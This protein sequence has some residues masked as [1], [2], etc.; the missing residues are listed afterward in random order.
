MSQQLPIVDEIVRDVLLRL[1]SVGQGDQ[2]AQREQHDPNGVNPTAN[3]RPRIHWLRNNRS[4]N[5]GAAYD[6]SRTSPQQTGPQPS[7][8]Q[9]SRPQSNGF[10]QRV[11]SDAGGTLR[12]TQG[13]V[14]LADVELRLRGIDR[15]E[16]SDQTIVTPAARDYL[17]QYKVPLC[18]ETAHPAG[19]QTFGQQPFGQKNS[20]VPQAA[21]VLVATTETT[22]RS[23]ALES[24]LAREGYQAADFA[25]GLPER[26]IEQLVQRLHSERLLGVLI[27]EH[28][29]RALALANRDP[30]VFAALGISPDYL[31]EC[32]AA[33]AV[34][35]LVVDPR[36]CSPWQLRHMARRL[37]AVG[38]A[39]LS[40]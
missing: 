3:N 11:V 33:M 19:L 39:H 17:N 30:R 32:L 18:R 15:V 1:R 9:P 7:R 29:G 28:T 31:E 20:D 8:P 23:A 34:N 25:G 27:T 40:D 16:V 22:Q 4:R 24:I 12:F 13:V 37:A 38:Q 2:H 10:L 36:M 6:V 21:P 14:S 26:A 35:L 5:N